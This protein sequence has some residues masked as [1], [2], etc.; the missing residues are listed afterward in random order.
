MLFFCVADLLCPFVLLLLW[1]LVTDS[2]S[3]TRNQLPIREKEKEEEGGICDEIRGSF[4]GPK[5]LAHHTYTHGIEIVTEN[6]MLLYR[7][8][9]M[10]SCGW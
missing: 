5:Q 9:R 3:F 1:L 10:K 6:M 2:L 7:I 4:L 8:V